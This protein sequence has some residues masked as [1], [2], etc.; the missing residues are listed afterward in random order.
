MNSIN[1]PGKGGSVIYFN[2]TQIDLPVQEIIDRYC[3]GESQ[4][5]LAKAFGVDR[6]TIR[7]RLSAAGIYIRNDGEASKAR[8]NNAFKQSKEIQS[9]IDGLLLG[10]AW[11]EQ[12]PCQDNARL[13]IEVN[14]DSSDWIQSISKV[15]QSHNI[16]HAVSTRKPRNKAINGIETTSKESVILRTS[17]YPNFAKQRQ[18]W[19][20]NGYK[21]VPKDLELNKIALAHW[22][23]GDG[24]TNN[25][26]VRIY[27]NNFTKND[28]DFLAEQL[29]DNFNCKFSISFS[30]G[31]P[32]LD[33]YNNSEREAF[34]ELIR[35]Y[36]PDCFAYK[37][38]EP[39]IIRR[40]KICR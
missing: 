26:L 8:Q 15:F 28:C 35:E 19:Y 17:P 29:L 25:Y 4:S 7:R 39:K 31:K 21:I 36:V 24:S 33:L 22:Y 20:P 6:R 18:R 11:I 12:K 1:S 2:M 34:L 23:C 37:V 10:D 38:V 9:I 27:T 5:C 14:K 13:A 32:I 16:K 3:R 40:S 30:R